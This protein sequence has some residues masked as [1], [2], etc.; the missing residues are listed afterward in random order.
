VTQ[1]QKLVTLLMWSGKKGIAMSWPIPLDDYPPC[2]PKCE[3]HMLR[4]FTVSD[5][6]S[7][8]TISML[9]YCRPCNQIWLDRWDGR[10][11]DPV[12]VEGGKIVGNQIVPE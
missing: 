2:C 4:K 5:P 8:E 12:K 1:L 6:T 10:D 7:G 3:R 9:Y 11:L